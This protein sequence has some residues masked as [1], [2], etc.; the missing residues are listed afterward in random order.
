LLG[1]VGFYCAVPHSYLDIFVRKPPGG[2]L[3]E[4]FWGDA[5]LKTSLKLNGVAMPASVEHGIIY[6]DIGDDI[7]K[8]LE[9][10]FELGA[11]SATR[12]S[13]IDVAN[14]AKFDLVVRSSAPPQQHG[15]LEVVVSYARMVSMCDA[16][17]AAQRPR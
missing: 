6:I 12:R 1:G 11:G 14:F 4:Y 7:R 3:A 16:T 13:T 9:M 2:V 17:I 8:V 15:D 5:T 10:V